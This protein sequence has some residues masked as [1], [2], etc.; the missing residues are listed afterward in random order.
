MGR[1]NPGNLD[2]EQTRALRARLGLPDNSHV[3]GYFGRVVRDKGI[4]ELARA[5]EIVSSVRPSARLLVMGKAE[6][7]DPVP[8]PVI[9]Y[10]N[11]DGSIDLIQWVDRDDIPYYYALLDLLVL[12][13]YREGLPNVILEA[14]A[15]GLPVVATR[16]T[17]CVDA[18]VDGVTGTLVPAKDPIALADAILVYLDDQDLRFAHGSAGREMVTHRFRPEMVWEFMADIYDEELKRKGLQ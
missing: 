10:L 18:V 8:G 14:S 9:R 6:P 11:E 2:P 17:G 7:H 15:M 16:V 12:P 13:T 4:M 5:W 3:V 1:F